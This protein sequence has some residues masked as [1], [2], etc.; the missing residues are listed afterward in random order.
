MFC[1]FYTI[2]NLAISYKLILFFR[3]DNPNGN[4]PRSLSL[5]LN[6]EK[7][8]K[9][10]ASNIRCSV[11]TES[12]KVATWFDESICHVCTKLE[13]P[14]TLYPEFANDKI[15]S[16]HTCVLYTAV[17]LESGA[18]YWWGV[19][20][21]NQR[22][23]LLDKYV[24]K[25]KC[26]SSKGQVNQKGSSSKKS[27]KSASSNIVSIGKFFLFYSNL[28]YDLKFRLNQINN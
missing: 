24:N 28:I 18:I 9:I 15:T 13:H 26:P 25:K 23:R 10:S 21:F 2:K 7:V 27:S 16:L 8:V 6:N 20:P 14:A 5:G 1:F 22:K 11:V 12:G 3:H 19:L 17:R 4:H